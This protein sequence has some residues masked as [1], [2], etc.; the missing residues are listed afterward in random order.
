MAS[1]LTML[2]LHTGLLGRAR[3]SASFWL[4]GPALLLALAAWRLLLPGKHQELQ[5]TTDFS[6]PRPHAWWHAGHNTLSSEVA[7]ADEA[8]Q[9]SQ[10]FNQAVLPHSQVKLLSL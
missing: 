5:L 10:C 8:G 4:A 7:A 3:P 6:L 9:A 1:V 2:Q